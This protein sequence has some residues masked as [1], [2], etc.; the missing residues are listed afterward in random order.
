MKS[1]NITYHLSHR[2]LSLLL[3]TSFYLLFPCPTQAWIKL[4]K[5]DLTMKAPDWCADANLI[6]LDKRIDYDIELFASGWSVNARHKGKIKVLQEEGNE[7]TIL[8][9]MVPIGYKMGRISARTIAPDGK[10]TK[11]K[12][13]NIFKKILYL[14]PE[15]DSKQTV[16]QIA[17]P[18]VAVGSI[19]EYQY[20]ASSRWVTFIPPCY[21]DINGLPTLHSELSFTIPAG[22]VYYA[23]KVNTRK[24]KYDEKIEDIITTQ[25]KK[26][27]YKAVVNQIRTDVDKPFAPADD[28]LRPH[29]YFVFARFESPHLQFDIVPTWAK[30]VE[31][32]EGRYAEFFKRKKSLDHLLEQIQLNGK[33]VF[34]NKDF[35]VKELKL[36]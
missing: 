24:C 15:K 20:E 29:I 3:I 6:G 10:K 31:I 7:Q 26:K 33:E 8:T 12:S 13:K 23:Q 21:F 30:A 11:V 32:L 34:V 5:T 28:F 1:S 36:K 2:V 35:D 14:G 25:G 22:T 17:F 27:C 4:E 19:L 16:Y 9:L 18:N